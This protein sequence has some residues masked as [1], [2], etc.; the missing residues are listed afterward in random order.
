MVRCFMFLMTQSCHHKTAPA[1]NYDKK[2]GAE[3]SSEAEGRCS[4]DYD[5]D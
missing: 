2:L 5:N 1:L 4:L 3:K